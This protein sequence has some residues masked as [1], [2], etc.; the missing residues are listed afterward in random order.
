MGYLKKILPAGLVAVTNFIRIFPSP[1]NFTGVN[2]SIVYGNAAY[3]NSKPMI[4]YPILMVLLVD[5]IKSFL[6]GIPFYGTFMLYTYPCYFITSL[7]A[8]GAIEKMNEIEKISVMVL[9][10][11]ILFFLVTNFGVFVSGG[12]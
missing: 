11:S 4:L 1:P 5:I 3:R 9:S 10:S 2:S 6:L 12:E 7:L 8:R